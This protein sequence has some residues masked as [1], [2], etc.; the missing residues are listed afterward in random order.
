MNNNEDNG[1]NEDE[2]NDENENA[3]KENVNNYLASDDGGDKIREG[4]VGSAVK[5][6]TD[7]E[8]EEEEEGDAK[9]CTDNKITLSQQEKSN[10]T[11]TSVPETTFTGN[12]NK[13]EEENAMIEEKRL[14][15]EETTRSEN[16]SKVTQQEKEDLEAT[17]EN[18]KHTKR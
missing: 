6:N 3:D 4:D 14:R 17:G 18:G 8:E 10:I 5:K 15:E 11:K 12:T 2:D 7:N 1:D 9:G 13:S 16:D